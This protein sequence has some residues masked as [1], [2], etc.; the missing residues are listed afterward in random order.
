MTDSTNA[1]PPVS[2]KTGAT[3][4]SILV[5]DDNYQLNPI[6]FNPLT[7]F[8]LSDGQSVDAVDTITVSALSGGASF[9]TTRLQSDSRIS[10]D[11]T[12]G[13]DG[14]LTY[15]GTLADFANYFVPDLSATC[16]T[17]TVTTQQFQVTISNSAGTATATNSVV[18][19]PDTSLAQAMISGADPQTVSDTA[20]SAQQIGQIFALRTANW[21][22]NL[23]TTQ[24]ATLTFTITGVSAGVG[25]VL[26]VDDVPSDVTV[27]G[28]D[29]T[30]LSLTGTESELG[31][32]LQDSSFQSHLAFVPGSDSTLLSTQQAQIGISATLQEQGSDIVQ[33]VDSSLLE[34][35]HVSPMT[36]QIVPTVPS[37]N[38]AVTNGHY[39]ITQAS[40]SLSLFSADNGVKISNGYGGDVT[41]AVQSSNALAGTLDFASASTTGLIGSV[42][43]TTTNGQQ[44]VSASFDSAADAAS[45]LEGV[46]FETGQGA[47]AA[48]Q[49]TTLSVSAT[50]GNPYE[51]TVSWS[52]SLQVFPSDSPSLTG[53]VQSGT[54]AVNAAGDATTPFAAA[55]INSPDDLP[56]T[57]TVSASGNSGL[58]ATSAGSDVTLSGNDTSTLTLTGTAA[59]VQAALRNATFQPYGDLSS[60]TDF[61]FS[62]TISNGF[63]TDSAT[64]SVTVVPD[65]SLT[66]PDENVDLSSLLKDSTLSGIGGTSQVD[67][68]TI[69]ETSGDGQ[70]VDSGKGPLQS[71]I[72]ADGKTLVL[73]GTLAEL[74]ADLASGAITATDPTTAAGATGGTASLSFT[75]SQDA[76]SAT[77]SAD[78]VLPGSMVTNIVDPDVGSTITATA[79]APLTVVNDNASLTQGSTFV[80]QDGSTVSATETG[81]NGDT[82]AMGVDGGS[83]VLSLANTGVGISTV[84]TSGGVQTVNASSS[85]S[86]VTVFSGAQSVDFTGGTGELVSNSS[87]DTTDWTVTGTSGGDNQLWLGNGAATIN[88]GGFNQVILGNGSGLNGTVAITGGTSADK[89]E[90]DLWNGSGTT[91]T[92][93]QTGDS[94]LT[95]F[96]SS[97][98]STNDATLSN[99]LVALSGATSEITAQDQ[100]TVQ[101]WANGGATTFTDAGTGDAQFYETGSGTFSV[102]DTGASTGTLTIGVFA[103][104]NATWTATTAARQAIIS[105]ASGNGTVVTGAGVVTA[106]QMADAAVT[107]NLGQNGVSSQLNLTA[108][109]KNAALINTSGGVQTV[110]ASSSTSQVT[111]FSGAQS[112]DF[113]GGTGELVSNSSGD[114]TDWTVTGTSGG[115]NQLWLGNGAATINAGGF[116]Q[117]IL[118]NGSGLNGTVAITGGTSADKEEVDL[119]NGSGT[120]GTVTQ[121]GDSYLTVFGSSEGSTNDATLSNGLVALS[122]ATSEITAQ[123]QGTVQ[124]WANGGATTF[125]DAGTGDAQ[126]YETGSG[127][128]SVKDTGASTGDATLTVMEFASASASGT[129]TGGSKK[130]DV[131]TGGG[132]LD[133]VAGSGGL[134][135]STAGTGALTLDVTQGSDHITIASGHT[136]DVTVIGRNL[137]A[138]ASFSISGTA[139]QA[140]VGSNLVVSL[141]DGH[142]VTFVGDASSNNMSLF[143]A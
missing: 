42:A 73:S 107:Y 77:A 106:Q 37:G 122:G 1:T 99:G 32:L 98:G 119:W 53:L 40:T 54:T 29:T 3:S 111:V 4:P 133:V 27:S 44:I 43:N 86:Q 141:D 135:L 137:N 6:I 142:T 127:T 66:V 30:T 101:V 70:F 7:G 13:S 24:V 41:V 81:R 2:R 82:F 92:V 58:L 55:V 83:S 108:T 50:N 25:G 125:T 87:G 118:G 130:L 64:S 56:V 8:V 49:S 112:V 62:T 102:K 28:N 103:G 126:F 34:D 12:Q 134:D 105:V 47:A 14:T 17:T 23:S 140:M 131:T 21:S 124:V 33:K 79:S 96:G 121:T 84:V 104:A 100:G 90:V 109:G 31:S 48:G 15:K 85:T 16:V 114:T 38:D 113:T 9:N 61:S 18:I 128:F 22:P 26:K 91:G 129:V 136:G 35:G 88:A 75:L 120:T 93:T 110:N 94:Y 52:E 11:F 59:E 143:L 67:V 132:S 19:N 72:S 57:V 60:S 71:A 117:V 36:L 63:S 89:E 68:L 80:L 76:D 10:S 45:F 46:N 139:S 5:A 39:S 65:I 95:V 78:V 123:D 116:N 74:K 138:D 115:D 51:S 69:K 20:G 97:E